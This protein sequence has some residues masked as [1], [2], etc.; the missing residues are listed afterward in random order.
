[1]DL[2]YYFS[3]RQTR[4]VRP[5]HTISWYGSPLQVLRNAHERSL[6]RQRITVH[7]T[8]EG[9]LYLYAG[10]ERLRY[11]VLPVAPAKPTPPAPAPAAAKAPGEPHPRATA[12]QR[13]WL[14]A[15]V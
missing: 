8:P 7:T 11:Q 2:A 6:T 12:R 10:K 5:D 13:A 9:E 4:V 3:T 15:S 1:M 14:F